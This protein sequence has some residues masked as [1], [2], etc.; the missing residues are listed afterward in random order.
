[1]PIYE[2]RC[3]TCGKVFEEWVKT[4]DSP[5]LEPCPDCGAEAE[6]IVSHTAF[7]LEGGGWFASCYGGKSSKP[8]GDSAAEKKEAAPA[9]PLPVRAMLPRRLR[10]DCRGVGVGPRRYLFP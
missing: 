4:F 3:R 10:P 1:M 6:R 2:Y 7:K 5:Q 8:E 9:A